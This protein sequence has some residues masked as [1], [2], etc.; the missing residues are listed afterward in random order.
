MK[1]PWSKPEQKNAASLIALAHSA[2]LTE[3]TESG[4]PF[5]FH[6]LK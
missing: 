2:A 6:L 1:L 4:F 5:R 3:D